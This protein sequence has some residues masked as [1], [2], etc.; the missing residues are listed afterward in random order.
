M[1]RRFSELGADVW[2]SSVGEEPLG[3]TVVAAQHCDVQ[4]RPAKFLLA[5]VDQ[6]RLFSDNL[7]DQLQVSGMVTPF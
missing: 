3:D 2:V 6:L 4:T 7:L 1:E 5:L